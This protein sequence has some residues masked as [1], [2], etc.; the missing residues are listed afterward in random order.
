MQ[1]LNSKGQNNQPAQNQSS[2][3]PNQNA[4]KFIVGVVVILVGV[5]AYFG[6]QQFLAKPQSEQGKQPAVSQDKTDKNTNDETGLAQ[7][8]NDATGSDTAPAGSEDSLPPIEE[9]QSEQISSDASLTVASSQSNYSVGDKFTG[10]VNLSSPTVPEGVEFVLSYDPQILT[11][12]NLEKGQS[13]STYLK[14]NVYQDKGK[15]KV[16]IIK[17]PGEEINLQGQ[18]NLVTISGDV[19]QAGQLSLSFD[20]EQTIVAATGGKDILQTT[21]DLTVQV[22]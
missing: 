2:F 7:I 14:T 9:D 4:L 18:T 6:Y 19:T 12:V 1:N 22:Q 15:I 20:E 13:F 3:S 16:V 21:E 17:N 5:G 8:D 10:Q 11:N